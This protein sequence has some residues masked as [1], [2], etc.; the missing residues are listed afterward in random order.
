V[1]LLSPTVYLMRHVYPHHE[2]EEVF[3]PDPAY[4]SL[5][6]DGIGYYDSQIVAV[7]LENAWII[8][9]YAL[10]GIVLLAVAYALYRKRRSECAG[11]VV[12]V[13][14]MKPVFRYGVSICAAMAG[15][16]ALYMVF[17]GQFQSG[18][19]YDAFPMLIAM[20][21]S[22]TIGY[23]AASMLLAKSLRVFRGSWKGLAI[24]ALC[25]AVICGVMK[26]D[27]LGIETRVPA[28]NQ[29]EML[30]FRAANNQYELTPETDA[31]L[32]EEIRAVHLAIAEDADYIIATNEDWDRLNWSQE[33][34]SPSNS[35]RL[36]YRL[37]NGTTVTRR[38]NVPV[39]ADRLAQED[40][41]DFALDRLVNS[42]TLKAK[43]FH[44]YD[45]YKADNGYLYLENRR[46]GGISFGTHE[47]LV[48]H[49][50]VK[51]DVAAGTCGTY[52]WFDQSRAGQYAIE[53]NLDF[54]TDAKRDNGAT[55]SY[56]DSINVAIY[57][58]MTHTV[59]ALLTL[60]LAEEDDFKTYAEMHPEDY[61]ANY[62]E[63]LEKFGYVEY[64]DYLAVRYGLGTVGAIDTP[65]ASIGVIGGA[66]GPTEIFVAAG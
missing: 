44:L 15:G 62:N 52:D 10:V 38:Y 30:T 7:S 24:T 4:G 46:D 53:L 35:V 29:I 54:Y 22:G 8:A 55:Y 19:K 37:K 57:P 34:I 11:D 31:E 5:T 12:A 59:E 2:Y 1:E 20:V 49:E 32:L 39:S 36:T 56:Y 23:Y 66:D 58:G 65:A 13:G 60:N 3:V 26:F 50:A 9:V 28:A 16:L 17:W 6:A 42:D 43:R 48:I 63:Y 45:G 61:D 14:W 18:S 64:D 47:A 51:R 27:L 25:A 40:T 21:I 41:Y 33:E